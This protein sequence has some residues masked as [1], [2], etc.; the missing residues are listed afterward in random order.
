[1]KTQLFFTLTLLSLLAFGCTS[2]VVQ[3]KTSAH[4]ELWIGTEDGLLRPDVTCGTPIFVDLVD[5]TNTV[6]GNVEV[7]NDNK[8][9]YFLVTMNHG[10]LLQGAKIFAGNGLNIPKGNSGNI[11]LEEFP[12]QWAHSRMT[13]LTTYIIDKNALPSCPDVV[14]FAQAAQVNMWGNPVTTRELWGAGSTV[15]NGQSFNYCIGN[16][17]VSQATPDAPNI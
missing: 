2:E 16:C 10:W 1:M 17:G 12:F 4:P 15:L 13:G 8:N 14:L 9:I 11:Q 6:M 5:A 7:L 3:P